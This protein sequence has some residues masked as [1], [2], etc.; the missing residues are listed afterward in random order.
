MTGQ[1]W[2]SPAAN[3]GM[4]PGPSDTAAGHNRSLGSHREHR[5]WR[6]KMAGLFGAFVLGPIATGAVPGANLGLH[7]PS[8]CLFRAITGFNCPVCGITRSV[9]LCYRFDF[10]AAIAQH[11]AGPLIAVIVILLFLYF[12]ITA[13]WSPVPSLSWRRETS[14]MRAVSRIVVVALFLSWP[15]TINIPNG[16]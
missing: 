7:V 6:A 3:P 13:S 5:M 1:A 4:S 16:G 15:F 14:L 9:A 10:S 12:L 11:P 2:S 8:F